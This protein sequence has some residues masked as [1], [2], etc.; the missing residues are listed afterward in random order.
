MK[1][2]TLTGPSGVGKGFLKEHIKK[3]WPTLVYELAWYT[4]RPI[5][6]DEDHQQDRIHLTLSELIAKKP[7]LT[8][9]FAGHTYGIVSTSV[10][11]DAIALTELR[12]HLLG[13]L[14]GHEVFSIAL[15]AD[16]SL[17]R[18]RLQHRN[19]ETSQDIALRI[20]QAQAERCCMQLKTADFSFF[21][22]VTKSNEHEI[23]RKCIKSIRHFMINQSTTNKGD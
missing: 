14:K 8:D 7:I 4:T 16:D 18:Q 17:L 9:V 2:I 21:Q 11:D 19:T 23:A 6:H 20:R 3:E 5:R 13:S 12:C 22:K 10:P 1:L 15:T